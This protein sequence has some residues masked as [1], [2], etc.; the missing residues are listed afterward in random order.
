[1]EYKDYYK[2]LG[3]DRKATPADIKKA[4]RRLARELHPDRNPGDKTAERRFKDVN[5]AHE[6]L[7]DTRKRQQYDMLGS[8]WDQYARAGGAGAGAA[9]EGMG[10]GAVFAP[11]LVTFFVAALGIVKMDCWISGH[12]QDT[13]RTAAHQDIT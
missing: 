7:A 13:L 5:E 8:N 12:G 4:Y 6:V 1:M 11:F 3:V 9:S 10:G 2:T